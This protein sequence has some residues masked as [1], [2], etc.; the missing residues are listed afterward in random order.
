MN[1]E[2]Y[3][4]REQT[5]IKHTLLR[6]YLERLFMIIGQ[7][8]E[9]ICYV[10]CFAGPWE[11]RTENLRDTSIGISLDIIQKCRNVLLAR[12]K[13]VQFRAL[14]VEKEKI[15]FEK[16]KSFLSSLTSLEID[17]ESFHGDFFDLRND[18][19]EWCGKEDFAFFFIDPTGWSKAIEIPTLWPILQRKKSEYLI[20][21]MFPFVLRAYN[22]SQFEE[23][24]QAIF[25]E[26]LDTTDMSPKDRETFLMKQYRNCLKSAQSSAIE[27]PRSA[28]V[29]VLDPYKDKTKYDLVYLTRHPMGIKEFMETSENV[30]IIQK[31][32]RAQTKQRRRIEKTQQ[33]EFSFEKK[34]DKEM[35]DL[36]EVKD[37]WLRKLSC[38]PIRFGVTE[39][40][41]MLEE[42]DWFVGD[43]QNA[44]R[45]LQDE[46]NVKNLD[47]KR[48]RSKN[49][50]GF[51]NNG[52]NGEYLRRL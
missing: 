6:A 15:P 41:D 26:V 36:S 10:D 52:G 14:F 13:D 20:N 48:R 34:Y 30:D 28:Y 51:R 2:D 7:Y 3:I 45:E 46:G 1:P 50:V 29:N 16:L 49:F 24:M 44:F 18:I 19:L 42:T 31:R 27:R 11:E 39:M 40:A 25:G 9:N 32:V 5:F 23:Q 17:T 35:E 21:F 4:G 47:A 12:G 8:Q 22:Q 37:Y 38:E 33:Y 43:F